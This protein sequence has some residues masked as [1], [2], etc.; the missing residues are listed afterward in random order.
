MKNKKRFNKWLVSGAVLTPLVLV[1]ASNSPVAGGIN[2]PNSLVRLP[3]NRRFIQTA[4]EF[5]NTL[6]LLDYLETKEIKE[7]LNID[8]SAS[9]FEGAINHSNPTYNAYTLIKTWI[10]QYDQYLNV[11]GDFKVPINRVN[12]KP[13]QW[14]NHVRD[15]INETYDYIRDLFSNNWGSWNMYKYF[16]AQEKENNRSRPSQI[17]GSYS[18]SDGQTWGNTRVL[19][20]DRLADPTQQKITWLSYPESG[21]NRG[22]T[23]P[24]AFND[25]VFYTI[26]KVSSMAIPTFWNTYLSDTY[27]NLESKSET[28]GITKSQIGGIMWEFQYWNMSPTRYGYGF[29]VYN[30]PVYW[31]ST[32]TEKTDSYNK[33]EGLDDSGDNPKIKNLYKFI[34]N[35]DS[36]DDYHVNNSFSGSNL[37]TK[38]EKAL[39]SSFKSLVSGKRKFDIFKSIFD[40]IKNSK[41]KTQMYNDYKELFSNYRNVDRTAPVDKANE[42]YNKYKELLKL[43]KLT[44]DIKD[45]LKDNGASL[46]YSMSSNKNKTLELIKTIEGKFTA[47]NSG[48]F[49]TENNPNKDLIDKDIAA[50]LNSFAEDSTDGLKNI[51]N[52]AFNMIDAKGTNKIS[53]GEN[54]V[55]TK[56]VLKT[57]VDNFPLIEPTISDDL[58]FGNG[59][60]K[61]ELAYKKILNDI[62]LATIP[63]VTYLNESGGTETK[64]LITGFDENDNKINS[65]LFQTFYN[66]YIKTKTTEIK[67][68]INDGLLLNDADWNNFDP[69]TFDKNFTPYLLAKMYVLKELENNKEYLTIKQYNDFLSFVVETEDPREVIAN[70]VGDKLNSNGTFNE[71]SYTHSANGDWSTSIS[72]P[73]KKSPIG[74]IL[75]V[76][77]VMKGIAKQVSDSN[78]TKTENG[79]LTNKYKY[80]TTTNKTD[81]DEKLKTATTVI[82]KDSQTTDL[83]EL[84]KNTGGLPD[85]FNKDTKISSG[86]YDDLLAATEKLDGDTFF[87]E[88][89]NSIDNLSNLLME[90][91]TNI[92]GLLAQTN[93]REDLEKVSND[94]KTLNDK[95]SAIS[96]TIGQINAQITKFETGAS[97]ALSNDKIVSYKQKIEEYNTQL[98]A[99][100]N[101]AANLTNDTLSNEVNTSN[102]LNT[103]VETLLGVNLLDSKLEALNKLT[104]LTGV[105]NETNKDLANK[106]LEAGSSKEN[107]NDKLNATI[108]EAVNSLKA[109][110]KKQIENNTLTNDEQTGLTKAIDGANDLDKL[111]EESRK[112]LDKLKESHKREIAK[113]PN[114]N[115]KDALNEELKAASSLKELTAILEKAKTADNNSLEGVKAK[116]TR[117]LANLTNLTAKQVAELTNE[118]KKANSMDAIVNAQTG[119]NKKAND[120][121]QVMKQVKD[122]LNN[123]SEGVKGKT[124]P[125]YSNASDETKTKFDQALSKVLSLTNN[126]SSEI[127]DEKVKTI[128][129]KYNAAK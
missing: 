61:L 38:L 73:S 48:Y 124:S 15:V 80:S 51:V 18:T 32:E 99:L 101:N 6:A 109:M 19:L 47:V 77:K 12:R 81:F 102:T 69:L 28:I 55:I 39:E 24:A 13:Q 1:A 64:P 106:I 123:T 111:A 83:K 31:L 68:P 50:L 84:L 46:A 60:D 37:H 98:E 30:S 44:I 16:A 108:T 87:T 121:N 14:R 119:I 128:I 110:F 97:S 3:K 118:I 65:G 67:D 74:Y 36:T 105:S 33:L 79:Q 113:L 53:F 5:P 78:N 122:A 20:R 88:K 70:Y 90:K 82:S 96:T 8:F 85:N 49:N 71:H 115:N 89:V 103:S 62:M 9:T 27:V 75:P 26:G 54:N 10:N 17:F 35:F 11:K 95:I 43:K 42:F 57:N 29:N 92:K 107:V 94:A 45:D 40:G 91:R 112:L 59:L 66:K 116:A 120:L 93:T 129:N 125:N 41:V 100:K 56:D 2:D 76:I 58:V 25:S 72:D 86:Y 114:I 104:K 21:N 4:T 34:T 23:W 126:E 7:T 52:K 127:N 22:K 63:K 117:D